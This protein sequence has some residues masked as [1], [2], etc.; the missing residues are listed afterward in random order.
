MKNCLL[1]L[2]ALLLPFNIG[3]GQSFSSTDSTSAA[4][5]T[6]ATAICASGYVYTTTYGCLPQSTCADGYAMYNNTCVSTTTTTTTAGTT[7]TT[8]CSS[9]YVYS[10]NYGCI[11]QLTCSSGYGWYNN[12]CILLTG[13]IITTVNHCQD[14]C[15]SGQIATDYGCMPAVQ[16]CPPCSGLGPDG[17]CYWSSYTLDTG[18]TY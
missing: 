2:A 15:P 9:G 4:T 18:L 1:I 13:T 16:V 5:G 7:S 17:Y 8:T 3:C 14:Y 10:T 6:T 12:S 11:P